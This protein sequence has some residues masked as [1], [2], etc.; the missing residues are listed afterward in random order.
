MQ[1]GEFFDIAVGVSATGIHIY[2]ERVKVNRFPWPK[3]LKMSYKN[4][5]FYVKIRPGE[6]GFQLCVVS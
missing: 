5:T 4:K 1:D 6:V 3:V 2:R